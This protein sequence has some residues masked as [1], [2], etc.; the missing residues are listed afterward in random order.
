[1]ILTVCSLIEGVHELRF[2]YAQRQEWIYA[3]APAA[4]ML[5]DDRNFDRTRDLDR[6]DAERAAST[7]LRTSLPSE[8]VLAT[9]C[10]EGAA[11]GW[12]FG[13]PRD[14]G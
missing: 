8:D 7:V 10:D 2:A 1:M 3:P 12:R 6:A 11:A 5:F 9:M 13:P 4:R 14:G